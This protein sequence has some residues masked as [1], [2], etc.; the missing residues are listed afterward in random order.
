M[1]KLCLSAILCL[2]APVVQAASGFLYDC[3]MVDIE[4]GYGWVSPKIAIVL[5][6]EGAVTVVDALTLTYSD[7]PVIGT[8]LRNT[9]QRLVVKW[10]LRNV[11]AD[12]GR[13]FAYFDY[14]ASIA[15][16][17]GAIDLR[18]RPRSFD[19]GLHGTGTCQKR[20]E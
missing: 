19:S 17:T 13:S 20:T 1:R 6:N 7:T 9:K 10:T 12:S 5:P 11:R 4:R 18:A 8:V 16:S 15:K 2:A 3:D 14:R